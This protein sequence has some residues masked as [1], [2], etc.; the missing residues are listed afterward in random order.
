MS[1]GGG[2]APE[3]TGGEGQGYW[4]IVWVQLKKDMAGM[5]GLCVAALLFFTAV[6][7]PL[8][9]NDR[10]IVC[11]YK[12]NIS[13]PAMVSYVD[14]WV[15]WRSLQFQLKS[16][17]VGDTLPLGDH[18]EELEG[19]T[20]LEADETEAMDWAV[21]PPIPWSPNQFDKNALKERPSD[22]HWLGTDNQGR[23]VL[24]RMVHGTVVAMLVGIISMSIAGS[25]GITL[26]L[27][28]GYFGG[29]I[30]IILSRI[31]EIVMCFPRFFLVI[32]VIAFLPPSIVNIMLVI[33]FLGWTGIFRL[34]RGE[35]LVCRSLDYVQ[36]ARAM[37]LPTHRILFKHIMPNAVSPVFVAVPFGIAAAVLMETSLSFLGFGDPAAPSW[38]EIVSQGRT[39]VSQGLWHLTIF[40]GIAIFVTLTSFNLFGQGLRDAMDPKLRK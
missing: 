39:Y 10:P 5:M 15:P 11:S 16:F 25:I 4:A 32:A 18:Y 38:G 3:L 30:D 40:P 14:T 9:A 1:G 21:W 19:L 17:K 26:G 28:A 35:T 8:I 29:W 27:I 37:G 13:A 23:D 2:G 12:G 31:T 24:A 20:W 22:A 33:G 36:A 34:V 7:A 6:G